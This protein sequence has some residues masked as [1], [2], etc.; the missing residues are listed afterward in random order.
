MVYIP[1]QGYWCIRQAWTFGG[2]HE[3]D[4][5][6]FQLAP[7]ICDKEKGIFIKAMI[8]QSKRSFG[9]FCGF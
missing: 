4:N 3:S 1:I 5:I 7:I 2:T 9:D 8:N 6:Q